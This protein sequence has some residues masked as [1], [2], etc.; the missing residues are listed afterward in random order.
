MTVARLSALRFFALLFLLP[1]LAGLILAAMISADYLDRMP[2]WPVPEQNRVVPRGIHG[3]TVYQTPAEDRELN[4]IE[5]SS[6]GVFLVG[7]AL[8]VLYLEQWGSLQ[9]RDESKESGL[10]EHTG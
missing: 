1:G 6:V 5:Y 8:G 3:T 2:K 4:T 7:L 10:A 9:T